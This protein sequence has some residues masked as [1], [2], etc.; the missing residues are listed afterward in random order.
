[1]HQFIEQIV[2]R[3]I[4]SFDFFISDIGGGPAM[5]CLGAEVAGAAQILIVI[6]K[7]V[8]GVELFSS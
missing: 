3:G 1:M 6:V 2:I 7:Q 8:E 4:C 5:E